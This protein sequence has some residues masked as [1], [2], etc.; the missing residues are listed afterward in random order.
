MV[1]PGRHYQHAPIAE[2][3]LDIRCELPP[4]ASLADLAVTVVDPAFTTRER[5]VDVQQSVNISDRGVSGE[6]TGQD[7]GYVFH[8]AD[9]RRSVRARLDGFGFSW[10]YQYERWESFLGEAEAH[11]LRYRRAVRPSKATR[12]AV[13][14]INKIDI[15]SS[16]PQAAIEIK[17]YL[18]ATVDVPGYL[19]QMISGYFLQ[20]EVPIPKYE[21]SATIISL[22]LPPPNERTTSLILD[23]DTWQPADIALADD[24]EALGVA[25]RFEI[26]RLAKNYVFES[27]ITDATRSLIR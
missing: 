25:E 27:C 8:R 17:D 16:G 4:D 6:T 21:C 12:L 5:S 15:P 18:R 1:R 14:Y 11:W 3:I 24:R 10:M 2:A 7:V 26:L 20:V 13:R 23:I 9:G 22:L 19:P